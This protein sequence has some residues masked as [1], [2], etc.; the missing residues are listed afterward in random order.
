MLAVM[1][2]VG[3]IALTAAAQ[4]A[5]AHATITL[6]AEDSVFQPGRTQ[7]IGLLFEM[8]PGWHIYWVNPGDAGDPPRP[9]WELPPGFRAGEIRWPT[10]VRLV[11][12]PVVDY[13]YEGRVLLAL[14]LDVP[15]GFA[16][17]ATASISADLRYLICREVCIP[18]R[19]RLSL[20]T[21]LTG[22]AAKTAGRREFFVEARARWPKA[23]PADWKVTATS[24]GP[25]ITLTLQ[26]GSR[27][28]AV[29]FYPLEADQID[30]VAPQ[31][32]TPTANGAQVALQRADPDARVP[33]ALKGVVVL[34]KDR[35]FEV[36][37]PL[38]GDPGRR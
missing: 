16:P 30:N 27:E 37:A 22:D 11:L 12:G 6:V 15:A 10:P 24:N 17:S 25:H 21:A 7:W 26:T 1:W 14:P 18:G 13:G 31:T 20:P 36:A 9:T 34:G 4:P 32:V 29:A 3:P 5:T 19:T 8:E 23:M 2:S 35:A 33:T 38:A 28:A